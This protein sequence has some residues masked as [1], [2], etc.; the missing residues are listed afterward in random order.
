LKQTDKICSRRFRSPDDKV[1]NVHKFLSILL[2]VKSVTFSWYTYEEH[3]SQSSCW[4]TQ[5]SS[6][7]V[8]DPSLNGHLY[9]PNDMDRSPNEVTP[10]KIRKYRSDYNNISPNPISF[11][12]DIT[13]TSGRLHSEFVPFYSNSFM[14]HGHDRSFTLCVKEY[15]GLVDIYW[16]CLLSIDKAMK[17]YNLK[18]RGLHVSHTLGCVCDWNT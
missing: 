3:W 10:N 13:S 16:V 17:D 14:G 9:Y 1:W 18:L 5:R 4:K 12:T 11:M 15:T 8:S 6:D 7:I 2:H